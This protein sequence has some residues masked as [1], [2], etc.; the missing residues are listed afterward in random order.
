[1]SSGSGVGVVVATGP[2]SKFGAIAAGLGTAEVETSFQAGLR[3][4]SMFLVY[5]GGTLTAA[6]FGINLVLHKPFIDALLFSLSLIHIYVYKRQVLT[7]RICRSG[8]TIGLF[9]L[10]LIRRERPT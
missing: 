1:M 5:V 8:S 4:F 10:A 6:I 3:R 7:K 9:G 2:H